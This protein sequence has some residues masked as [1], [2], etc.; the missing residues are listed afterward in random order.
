MIEDGINPELLLGHKYGHA[1]H[2]WDLA[3]GK[4]LQ[5]VDLGEQHQMVLELRPAHD[6]EATWGFVG[7]VISHRGPVRLGLALAPPGR[8]VGAPTR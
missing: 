4:H 3:A 2:F 8:P 1:L 6:P 7:V 5:A